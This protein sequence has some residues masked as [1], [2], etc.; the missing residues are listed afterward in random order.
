MRPPSTI[1]RHAGANRSCSRAFSS[2][3][4]MPFGVS[5]E[6]GGK[7]FFQIW[8]ISLSPP[9]AAARLDLLLSTR[10]LET[11]LMERC[12][13]EGGRG[14]SDEGRLGGRILL[15][16]SGI[17]RVRVVLGLHLLPNRSRTPQLRARSETDGLKKHV[18]LRMCW[19]LACFRSRSVLRG[20][21]VTV[22][23]RKLQTDT[24]WND[25]FRDGTV[26]PHA[27]PT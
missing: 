6:G 21:C 24:R 5:A 10:M 11:M 19:A 9:V 13:M 26:P 7:N 16:R 2:P 22:S 4:W 20:S 12:W 15:G 27:T 25:V 8:V 14:G 18:G 3:C 1:Q 17:V 23:G